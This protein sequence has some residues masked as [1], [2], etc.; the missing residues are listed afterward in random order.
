MQASIDS[1]DQS[2]HSESEEPVKGSDKN[3]CQDI[4]SCSSSLLYISGPLQL[5]AYLNQQIVQLSSIEQ[6]IFRINFP[7]KPPPKLIS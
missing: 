7:P 4:G 1:S 5:A 6:T 2:C 3:C